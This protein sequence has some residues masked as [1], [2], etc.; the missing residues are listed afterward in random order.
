MPKKT[1]ST[2]GNDDEKNDYRHFFKAAVAAS[3]GCSVRYKPQY[4]GV[5]QGKQHTHTHALLRGGIKMCP[6]DGAGGKTRGS[7]VS[8]HKSYNV[9]CVLTVVLDHF[10]RNAQSEKVKAGLIHI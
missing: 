7:S 9:Q 4:R 8:Y 1:Y 5:T 2:W 3:G 6:V 10:S